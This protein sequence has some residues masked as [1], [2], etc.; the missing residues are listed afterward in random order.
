M[1]DL[2]TF[3]TPTIK[4]IKFAK[5]QMLIHDIIKASNHGLENGKKRET[6]TRGFIEYR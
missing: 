6:Y 4:I 2:P 1:R 5:K 3:L